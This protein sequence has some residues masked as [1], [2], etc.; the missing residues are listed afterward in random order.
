MALI[1]T[2]AAASAR[3]FGLSQSGEPVRTTTWNPADKNAGITLS[4][5][6]LTLQTSGVNQSVRASVGRSRGRR[7]FEVIRV[8]GG[9]DVGIAGL[10]SISSSLSTYIGG[11]ATSIG[12]TRPN[13]LLSTAIVGYSNMFDNSVAWNSIAVDLEA[14]LAWFRFS[15][16]NWNLNSGLAGGYSDA[17]VSAGTGGI[18]I[19]ALGSIIYPAAGSDASTGGNITANFGGSAFVL[20]VPSGFVSWNAA[21]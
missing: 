1:A 20:T 3:G 15:T 19:S 9:V 4:G 12:S 21:V 11:T 13:T 14:N 6:D 18:D 5:G 10:A 7:Y 16:N 2:L 8:S 17:Q